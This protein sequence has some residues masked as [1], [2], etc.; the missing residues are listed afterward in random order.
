MAHP[1][2]GTVSSFQPYIYQIFTGDS[3]FYVCRET[4]RGNCIFNSSRTISIHAAAKIVDALGACKNGEKTIT[5]LAFDRS[6]KPVTV[7][8]SR[9]IERDCISTSAV[10][11][12][13]GV[14]I[15]FWRF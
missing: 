1:G 7:S 5:I 11:C 2:L 9:G 13:V 3:I 14:T 8:P 10:T 15:L 6:F 12:M 4:L